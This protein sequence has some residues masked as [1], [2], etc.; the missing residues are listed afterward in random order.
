MVRAASA[1]TAA[2]C[3]GDRVASALR[4]SAR[5]EEGSDETDGRHAR[6]DAR[7][8]PVGGARRGDRHHVRR[9]RE[10]RQPVGGHGRDERLPRR[11]AR[12]P[13]G[14]HPGRPLRRQQLAG[15]PGPDRRLGGRG[16]DAAPARRRLVRPLRVRGRPPRP[17]RRRRRQRRPGQSA[18]TRGG[19]HDPR[20][21]VRPARVRVRALRGA[22][23]LESSGGRGLPGGAAGRRA[24]GPGPGRR[25]SRLGAR[26][27]VGA[28]AGRDGPG[29]GHRGGVRRDGPPASRQAS[30]PLPPPRFSTS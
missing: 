13:D 19:R 18:G 24:G 1:L 15:L 10:R 17:V 22:G 30:R 5:R 28:R 23:C 4:A 11:G 3:E 27:R 2:P 21:P 20:R 7:G 14:R 29:P 16:T 9:P 26:H 25:R 12:A 8:D 6:W